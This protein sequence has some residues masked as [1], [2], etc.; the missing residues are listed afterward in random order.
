V[1]GGTVDPDA[2]DDRDERREIQGMHRLIDEHG[3]DDRVRWIEMQTDR[4]TVGALYRFVADH[5]GAFVQPATFEAFGLTV[6]E[7][8]SSGLPTL[9]TR[10]G[11][12]LEI[13]EDGVSGF[14]IDPMSDEDATKVLLDFLTRAEEDPAEWDRLSEGAIERVE[15]RYT[16]KRYA[17]R[18]LQLSRIYGFW[19]HITSLEREETRRY[20]DMFY[21]LMYRPRAATISNAPE[22]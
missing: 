7:A 19:R 3:L 6:V 2:S 15:A 4:N 8:M 11:G 21:G 16:W 9:A 18:L 17:E 10:Y 5:R 20:L 13:I 14:H 12:P 1:V 22:G